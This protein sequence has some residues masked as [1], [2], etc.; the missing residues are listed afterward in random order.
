MSARTIYHDGRDWV[1]E[2]RGDDYWCWPLDSDEWQKGM[3]SGMTQEDL[4]LLFTGG[5]PGPTGEH[6]FST[7]PASASLCYMSQLRQ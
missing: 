4:N 2:Q 3:P 6:F 1:I 7:L 5:N